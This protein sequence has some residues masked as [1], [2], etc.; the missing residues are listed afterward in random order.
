MLQKS[1]QTQVHTKEEEVAAPKHSRMDQVMG[2]PNCQ[3]THQPYQLFTTNKQ[4]KASQVPEAKTE[5]ED[6]VMV[7]KR[8]NQEEQH[9]LLSE[10]SHGLKI[11]GH[12]GE[13]K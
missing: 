2:R 12:E 6:Q 8:A 10:A 9:Y 11:T 13:T 3:T 4:D 1:Q 7:Q 5:Q